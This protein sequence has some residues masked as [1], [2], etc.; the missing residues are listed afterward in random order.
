M[1]QG[2]AFGYL[3]AAAFARALVNTTGYGW[4]TYFWFAACPVL[5][6]AFRFYLPETK[7]FQARQA[8]RKEQGNLAEIFI[9]EGRVA[10]RRHWLLLVYLVI[11]TT[12]LNFMA[13]GT[14]DLYPTLLENDFGFSTN[15]VTVT[16]VVANL[17]AISGGTMVGYFSQFLGR[18]LSMLIVCIIGGALVYPYTSVRTEAVMAA[19]FFQQFCIE[20]AWSVIPIY[21][22]EL[23]PGSFQTFML[24]I[25][26]L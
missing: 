11:L 17:A 13:H 9:A 19:A 26:A 20:G 10:I 25:S 8:I 23:S 14:Q 1:Q 7:A 22:M 12:G 18:R 2:Y 3:L 15:A 5:I 24:G 4:R 6:I 21:V 16:Q